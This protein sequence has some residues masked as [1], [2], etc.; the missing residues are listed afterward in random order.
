MFGNKSNQFQEKI[1]NFVVKNKKKILINTIMD[2][3]SSVNLE[4]I[5]SLVNK[6]KNSKYHQSYK[7]MDEGF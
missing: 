4:D 5:Q 1:L 2:R 3:F 7:P 6:S